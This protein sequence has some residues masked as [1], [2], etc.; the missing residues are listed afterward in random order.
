MQGVDA[1]LEQVSKGFALWE[2]GGPQKLPVWGNMG[3]DEMLKSR[4]DG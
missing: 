4:V 3:E 1:I 2:G